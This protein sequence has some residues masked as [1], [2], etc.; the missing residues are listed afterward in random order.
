MFFSKRYIGLDIGTENIKMAYTSK[1]KNKWYINDLIKIDNPLKTTAFT[2]CDKK[3][4]IVD[5]IKQ[6]LKDK[7]RN[8]V[9]GVPNN[10]VIFRSLKFPK[11]KRKEI[12]EA[13]YWKCQEFVPMFGGDFVSDFEL[14]DEGKDRF[15]ILIAAARKSFI[16]DY[17]E[18]INKLNLNLLALDIYPLSGARI[19][20]EID[21]QNIIAI[22]DIG[23]SHSLVNIV[24]KGNVFFCRQILLGSYTVTKKIAEELQITRDKAE[25]LKKDPGVL[26][27][28]IQ[29][30]LRP[31]IKKFAMEILS[32]FNIYST[33]NKG[34]KVNTV[35]LIGDRGK[36]WFTKTM[37]KD[38]LDVEIILPEEL[39]L[40]FSVSK[41]CLKYNYYDFLNAIGFTLRG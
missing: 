23:K 15:H 24:E 3:D 19:L 36:L 9:V 14:I 1:I 38:F 30:N 6:N 26:K 11:L 40:G 13:V 16:Y 20:R 2:T 34:K 28:T 37:L 7:Y 39:Q 5:K 8:V 35:L 17:I 4:I 27:E 10:H 18:I 25:L 29:N 12:E 31:L 21:I 32:F 41:S 33:Q 22:I